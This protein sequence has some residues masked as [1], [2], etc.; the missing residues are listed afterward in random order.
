VSITW[1]KGL[2][3]ATAKERLVILE[4]ERVAAELAFGEAYA[5]RLEETNS[6]LADSHDLAVRRVDTVWGRYA[7]HLYLRVTVYH[8]STG[9]VRCFSWRKA[10]PKAARQGPSN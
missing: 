10:M 7:G 8:R 2:K 1:R 9:R 6:L 4:A 3:A 5:R